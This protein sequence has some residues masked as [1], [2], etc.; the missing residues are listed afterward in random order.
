MGLQAADGKQEIGEIVARARR[1]SPRAKVPNRAS[2]LACNSGARCSCDLGCSCEPSAL[3]GEGCQRSIA[4]QS[5]VDVLQNHAVALGCELLE[6]AARVDDTAQDK[7]RGRCSLFHPSYQ[8]FDLWRLQVVEEAGIGR[9]IVGADEE[10]VEA[11]D[12][13]DRLDVLDRL[14]RLDLADQDRK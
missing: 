10:D 7:T 1:D 2:Q 3:P 12:G 4:Q 11:L 8:A 13:R 14:P 6:T 5:R 9:Q